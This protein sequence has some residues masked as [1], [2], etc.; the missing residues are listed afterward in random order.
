MKIAI[1]GASGR[2]G[3]M[4]IETVLDD[5]DAQLTGVL[6]RP[7]SPML[8]QDAG[9]PLG[10]Q[11]G[12][13]ITDDAEQ[14][15]VDSEFLIDFTRP[16]ATLAYLKAARRHGVKLIVGTTGFNDAQKDELQQARQRG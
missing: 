8:G 11:T 9:A 3:R 16:E 1:A 10:R 14:A 12:V 15:L 5:P 2:M 7:G 4:L 13:L 6:D